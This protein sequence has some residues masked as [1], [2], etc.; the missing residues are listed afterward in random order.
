MAE[1]PKC[2]TLNRKGI[3]VRIDFY[4]IAEGTRF[5][6]VVILGALAAGGNIEA[7]KLIVLL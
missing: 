3:A 7:G 4:L 1:T 5:V 2:R 6:T